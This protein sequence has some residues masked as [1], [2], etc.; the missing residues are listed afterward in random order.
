MAKIVDPT[1]E[2]TYWRENHVF[3]PYATGASFDDYAPAYNYGV[4]SYLNYEGHH[5][6]DVES[7]L[8]R[9]CNSALSNSKLEWNRAKPASRDAWDRV[10]DTTERAVLGDSDR[11]GKKAN[12]QQRL[13]MAPS[14][15]S[16]QE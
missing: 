7:D 8:A 16:E 12:E 1:V 14:C 2:E 13:G 15:H 10:S 6:D 11:D 4:S 9:D 3:R 5:F